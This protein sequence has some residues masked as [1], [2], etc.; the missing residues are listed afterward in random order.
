MNI[1]SQL[2]AILFVASKSLDIKKIA[3]ILNVEVHDIL[4]TLDELKQKYSGI[5]GIH[6]VMVGETVQMLTN[7]AYTDIVSQFVKNDI[8]GDLSKAQLETLTVIAY[9]GPITR[10]E[11][12]EIRGVNCAVIVRNLIIRGLIIE[13]KQSD[14]ILPVYELSIDALRFLGISSVQELPKYDTLS[15]HTY[16]DQDNNI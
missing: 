8:Q 2:E 10:P 14:S 13:H 5:S 7:P 1:V 15:V 4:S 16:L 3:K 12:E 6:L 9:R 11:L